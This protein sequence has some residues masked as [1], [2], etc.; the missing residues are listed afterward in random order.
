MM[1][2]YNILNL[3]AGFSSGKNVKGLTPITID[4]YF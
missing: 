1:R 3:F 4:V 2:A